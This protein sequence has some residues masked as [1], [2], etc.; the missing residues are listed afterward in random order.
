MATSCTGIENSNQ[1]Y[2]HVMFLS[3]IYAI[4]HDRTF[5]CSDGDFLKVPSYRKIL[6]SI[7]GSRGKNINLPIVRIINYG[8][9]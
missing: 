1:F 7:S 5:V 4:I 9:K 2:N 3:V 8:L 6:W